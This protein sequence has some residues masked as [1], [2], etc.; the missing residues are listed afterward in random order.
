MPSPVR[1]VLVGGGHASV[2]LLRRAA[3]WTQ[4]GVAVTLV[5][6]HPTLYYSGMVPEYLGGVYTAEEAQIDLRAWC[7]RTGVRWLHTAATGLALPHRTVHTSAGVSVPYDVVAFDIGSRT[8]G[9]T[10]VPGTIPTKPLHRIE[11]LAAFVR[12]AETA[13]RPQRLVIVGGGAAGVEVGLNV[14]ARVPAS[15]LALTLLEPG[16]RLL[17]SMPP[18][19]GQ[20]AAA[21]LQQRGAS[22]RLGSKAAEA[23]SDYAVL[24]GG[25]RL[26]ADAVLWATGTTGPGLFR[27]AGLP[28][29]DRGF[30]RVT[31][32][33]HV[34]GD[35]AVFAA[36]DC[37]VVDGHE[38]L[39]R[40]GV[41]AV[42]QGPTL[43]ANV[44]RAVQALRQQGSLARVSFSTFRP[45]PVAPLI[46]STG[47]PEGLLVAGSWWVAAGWA[48]RLKH[49][50]DLRWMRRYHRHLPRAQTLGG[51][52]HGGHAGA[53][54]PRPTARP[55]HLGP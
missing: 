52:L 49:A 33:L 23:G 13:P 44:D 31:P 25:T 48:L 45:Y 43:Y 28:C 2:Y 54:S 46:L 51:L 20:R 1:L 9:H 36:G 17:P 38:D 27:L 6:D 11:R 53:A 10:H 30:V 26:L 8:P 18:G 34:P 32:A 55:A 15:R 12:A 21:L 5:S 41:H 29:D 24:T 19:A 37:A 4:A 7:Q 16:D 35:P 39:A 22:V 47:T 50:V 40:V 14:T 42:K 3:R